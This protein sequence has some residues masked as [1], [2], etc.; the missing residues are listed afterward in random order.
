MKND[1]TLYDFSLKALDGSDFN[2]TS[3]KGKVVLIVNTAS[4]C[5]F[6]GQYAGLEQL[7]RQYGDKGLQIIGVP[8]NQFANQEPGSSSEIAEFCKLTYDVSF[9][10]MAK[11][12]VNGK[13]ADPLFVWLKKQAPGTLGSSVKWN[14]TKFLVQKDGRTVKR[15]APTVEPDSLKG[16]IEKALQ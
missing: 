2:L 16:D 14:F 8:C 6:T 9:P 7:H 12:D 13:N 15:Y 10:L 5:G 3:L 1:L 11:V 4:K